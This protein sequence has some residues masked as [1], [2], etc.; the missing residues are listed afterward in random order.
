MAMNNDDIE[1]DIPNPLEGEGAD[2]EQPV[3]PP[4]ELEKEGE[5]QED[6]ELPEA[7]EEPTPPAGLTKE[8]ITAILREVIPAAKKE[9][10]APRLTPEEF[11]RRFNV[12]KP[13][14]KLIEDLRSEDPQVALKAIEELRDGL[15]RQAYTM[16][17]VRM[18]QMAEALLK[19]YIA[20]VMTS[21]QEQ[22]AERYETAFYK[23]YPD[24]SKYSDIV[25]AVAIRLNES[26]FKGSQKEVFDR[27]AQDVRAVL[28]K[29]GVK[30][31]EKSSKMSTL[32]RGG[33]AGGS[34]QRAK[35]DAVSIPGME[36]FD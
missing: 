35:T 17:D 16:A 21:V 4:Q 28:K 15:V 14:T 18:Q 22:Q 8:D 33:Q 27:V 31:P 24:L 36:V 9:D 2:N 7:D 34:G 25:D 26:G 6:G 32:T 12:F 29:M 30:L 19:Q 1:K 11:E 23:S 20:P 10:E 3:A 13:S 5:P